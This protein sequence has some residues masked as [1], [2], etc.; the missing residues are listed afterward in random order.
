[1][2]SRHEDAGKK[3]PDLST[4]QA[5]V[6]RAMVGAYVG[7]AAPIGS[8][9]L[10]NL[11]P[12]KISSASIR[13]TLAELTEMGLTEQPHKSAGRVPT[14]RGLRLFVDRLLDPG[15]LGAYERHA[16]AVSM[17][18]AREDSVVSVASQL[19]SECTHQLGFVVT[20]RL[21]CI[22]L[23]H[24]SLVRL[25]SERVLVV[26]YRAPPQS[27]TYPL[28]KEVHGEE[29]LGLPSLPEFQEV[30]SQ[31][32]IDAQV[33]MLPALPPR[34]FDDH[35]QALEQLSGRLY[36]RA[37]TP[38][39]AALEAMLPDWLEHVD[40]TWIIRGSEP[41]QPGLIRWRPEGTV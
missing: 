37:G 16:I 20:P 21:D 35:Q 3:T 41:L 22:V 10:A 19:L 24:V 14:E 26:L 18:E 25:S 6:L 30:L 36:L 40:G 13:N 27:Q 29:R 17:D 2:V 1:M 15:S 11:L 33:D 5:S 12:V 4:R 7:E 34:G 38:Q 32:R 9:T 31:L 8:T 39:M 28:W 23:K